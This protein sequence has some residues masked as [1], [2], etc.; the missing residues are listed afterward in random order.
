MQINGWEYYNHAAIPTTA[1]HENPNVLP[2][3]DGSIWNIKGA[4][5]ARWTTEFDC[6]YETNWWYV[7]KRAPFEVEM[8][9]SK[10]KKHI[11]QSLKKV[12]VSLIDMASYSDAL[13]SI[14]N[15]ACSRYPSYTGSLKSPSDFSFNRDRNVECWGAFSLHT[16][17]LIGYMICRRKN[18]YVETASAKYDPQYLN[19]RASDAIHFTILN[20]YLNQEGYSYISSGS[21]T[22]NHVT[23]AQDYKISTF[24]FYKAYCKL[25]LKFNPKVEWFFRLLFP[26]RR[27]LNAFD[28]IGLIHQINAVIKMD[29][30]VREEK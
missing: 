20:Y 5:L 30:L 10:T 6:G 1:P 13:S 7:I 28:S 24:G 12:R 16:G 2:I 15:N 3:E 23:N 26:I 8:L 19:L 4:L 17:Q 21:R 14:H 29:E 25:H 27:I 18:S 22:I 9:D 11:R